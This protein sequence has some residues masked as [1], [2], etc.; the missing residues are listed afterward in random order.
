LIDERERNVLRFTDVVVRDVRAP[1]DVFRPVAEQL[2]NRAP[3]AN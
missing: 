1:E 2:S 3:Y